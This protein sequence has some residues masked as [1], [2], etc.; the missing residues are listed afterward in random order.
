[1][2]LYFPVRIAV[3]RHGQELYDIYP[4]CRR[5]FE[6]SDELLGMKLSTLM[7]EGPK[8]E[9]DRPKIRSRLLWRYQ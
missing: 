6:E 9:L 8:E 5:V 3:R 2:H 7:F 1:M 4:E